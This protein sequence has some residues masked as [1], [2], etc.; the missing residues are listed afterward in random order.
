VVVTDADLVEQQLRLLT[1]APPLEIAQ[2]MA[3]DESLCLG[4]PVLDVWIAKVG[5]SGLRGQQA[6]R[7][8]ATGDVERDVVMSEDGKDVLV[9]GAE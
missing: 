1:T 4:N 6:A 9:T 3:N 7:A 2:Q 8:A 5:S